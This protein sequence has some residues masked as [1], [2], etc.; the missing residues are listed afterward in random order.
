MKHLTKILSLLLISLT[1]LPAMAQR[2]EKVLEQLYQQERQAYLAKS[3]FVENESTADWDLT[4]NRLEFFVDPNVDYIEGNVHF[5][6]TSLKD[7]LNTLV[8]DL[9]ESLTVTSIVSGNT[10]CSYTLT[11]GFIHLTLPSTLQNKDTGSFTISYK[12]IPTSTGIDAFS[13]DTQQ[14]PDSTPVI[15]TLSEPYGAKEWWPCKQSLS[16][17]IDSIDIIV[18]TPA[19]YR[20]ASNGILVSDTIIDDQR[21]CHW[22]HRH[23]IATYLVFISSTI[24]EVYSDWATLR[25]GTKVEI[26]NYVYPASL[27]TARKSTPITAEYMEYFSSHFMDYPFKDE[28]YG[29]AQFGWNGGME[30]QTMSSMGSFGKELIAHELSHQWFGDYITCGNWH[31]LWLNEGFATFMETLILEVYNP[32]EFTAWKQIVSKYVT[33]YPG[34]SV[35]IPEI[36]DVNRLFNARLTYYKGSYILQMLRV[37]LGDDTFFA[38]MNR[39]LRDPRVTDGFAT[40]DIFRENMEQAADTTLTEY[41]DNW[42]YGKG[43]P[44]YDI[45]SNHVGSEIHIDISQ[46]PSDINGPFFKMKLPFTL[47]TNGTEET[48]WLTNTV[49]NQQFTLHAPVAP[50]SIK[51]N[52]DNR[53]LCAYQEN[54]TSLSDTR[55]QELTVTNDPSEHSL[56]VAIA[57][58]EAADYVIFDQQGRS[59]QT[60]KWEANNPVISTE[61]LPPGIYN[62]LLTTSQKSY[63]IKISCK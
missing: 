42:V 57:E 15:Y 47:Y 37:L 59:V 45:R 38:G 26:L 46:K 39:Y 51:F 33:S 18:H 2:T 6:F 58:A 1:T 36:S 54:Y 34:G 3:L 14:D 29:H 24:Y 35:Y 41:F 30:N 48:Y 31:E 22:Q 11:E 21:T 44:I 40:T 61:L 49:Q 5:H 20:T 17:K 27:D 16:D 62:L 28:K 50:D 60:G 13:Q 8:I 23:P 43:H 19:L 10:P 52:K 55:T 56:T 12:G 32:K 9:D 25:D 53:I 4:Y 63:S 7:N